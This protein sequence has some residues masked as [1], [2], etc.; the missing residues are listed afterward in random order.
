M[1][2]VSQGPLGK[3]SPERCRFRFLLSVFFPYFFLPFSSVLTNGLL[4]GSLAKGFLRKVCGNSAE[5]LR[6]IRGNYVL[7]RA[8]SL[9]KFRGN[10]RKFFCDDPFPNDPI[11]ELLILSAS[12]FFLCCCFC[13]VPIFFL[14]SRSLPLVFQSF[15]QF[16]F[17]WRGA[18]VK[19]KLNF[20]LL[21]AASIRW[22]GTCAE[23]SW[24][25]RFLSRHESPHE[26]CSEVFPDI[27][28]PFFKGAQTMKCKT[29]IFEVESA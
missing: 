16:Y 5:I 10:L 25:E 14:F 20:S 4:M 1:F 7:L 28:E 3:G 6:K 2:L 12:I 21:K 29:G 22:G 19:S 11:S 8:E 18:P 26:G 17:R 13:R 15:L 24:H 23:R 27:F 9:R